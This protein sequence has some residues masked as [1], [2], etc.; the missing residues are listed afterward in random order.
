M[1]WD[2]HPVVCIVVFL[3]FARRHLGTC[4]V[5]HENARQPNVCPFVV[6]VAAREAKKKKTPWKRRDKKRT[7]K[8]AL[9]KN[10]KP[11]LVVPQLGRSSDSFLSFASSHR[12]AARRTKRGTKRGDKSKRQ[13]DDDCEGLY[14]KSGDR[15]LFSREKRRRRRRRRRRRCWKQRL[16]I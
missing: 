9:H 1:V 5:R 7:K 16:I 6:V 10:K 11:V 15:Q 3:R 2:Y 13:I 12:R 4:V 14:I 8:K